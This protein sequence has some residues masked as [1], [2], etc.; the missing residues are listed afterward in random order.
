MSFYV[1]GM[2]TRLS[3][4]V[5]QKTKASGRLD[6]RGSMHPCAWRMGR[7]AGDSLGYYAP[8]RCRHGGLRNRRAG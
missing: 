3:R 7:V 5:A 6:M 8:A 2:R 1:F 4:C